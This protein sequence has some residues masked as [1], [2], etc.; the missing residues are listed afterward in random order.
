MD[1]MRHWDRSVHRAEVMYV[2]AKLSK[3]AGVAEGMYMNIEVVMTV[4]G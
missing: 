1:R 2:D 4:P 3:C